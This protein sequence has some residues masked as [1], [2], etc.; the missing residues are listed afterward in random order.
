MSKHSENRA[1]RESHPHGLSTPDD[2]GRVV[3]SGHIVRENTDGLARA[4]GRSANPAP[5]QFQ[6][7]K[8]KTQRKGDKI[9][10]FSFCRGYV[11]D[12]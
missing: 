9:Q 7:Q 2:R 4:P 5:R 8:A 12:S 10:P 11:L 6:R 1:K 3:P